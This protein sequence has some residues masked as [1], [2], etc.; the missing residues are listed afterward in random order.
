M[1]PLS[2]ESTV[3][4]EGR[5]NCQR[6]TKRCADFPRSSTS[7]ELLSAPHP[8]SAGG[9]QG[10]DSMRTE[11]RLGLL[12]LSLLALQCGA[13]GSGAEGTHGF[14]SASGGGGASGGSPA[15]SGASSGATSG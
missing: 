6:N 5:P 2:L 13:S 11:A 7:S 4:P 10:M 9:P 14:P 8:G 12:A 1:H 15:S 3:E